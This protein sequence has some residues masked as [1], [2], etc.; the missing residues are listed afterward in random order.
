[1]KEL[2]RKLLNATPNADKLQH[3][4]YGAII[5]TLV[6][7]FFGVV[8][9][10]QQVQLIMANGIVTIVAWSKEF[11]VDKRIGGEVSVWDAVYTMLPCF[12][13][14]LVLIFGN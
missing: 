6:W 11:Y 14:L 5:Y 7:V 1:M 9:S 3:F 8:G 12:L 4:F 2:M 13:F 10:T